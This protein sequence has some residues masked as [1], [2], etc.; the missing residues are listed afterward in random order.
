M[1]NA[2]EETL[3]VPLIIS[4]P[5]LFPEARETAA[6]A[7]LCDLLPTMAE[8][9]GVDIGSD[10]VRGRSLAPVLR[11][12]RDSV[13]EGTL[14]TFDDHQSGSAY[15][16]VAPQPNRIRAWRTPEATYAEYVDPT[17][18]TAPE[19]ELYDMTRDPLQ[20]INLVDRDTGEVRDPGD[21]ELLER[22][23]KGLRAEADRCGVS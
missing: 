5:V 19:Y 3:N 2:Y 18:G 9:A 16:D 15:R 10:G 21:R 11:G 22:M 6:P 17:G 4:N 20:T 8:L 1:F 12:E 7:S 14:F 23:R 13:Q